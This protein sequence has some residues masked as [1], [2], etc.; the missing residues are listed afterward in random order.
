M[1][2][3]ALLLGILLVAAGLL[4]LREPLQSQL[5]KLSD[6]G[7]E[8]TASIPLKPM[9]LPPELKQNPNL[10]EKY[11]AK[12]RVRSKYFL[13]SQYYTPLLSGIAEATPW[14]LAERDYYLQQLKA[15]APYDVLVVPT[16][17]AGYSDLAS[18]RYTAETW[19]QLL[20]ANDFNS[21]PIQPV[22]NILGRHQRDYSDE[23]V[24]Q[25]ADELKVKAIY[26][27]YAGDQVDG[28]QGY[29]DQATGHMVPMNR[30]LK[31][32]VVKETNTTQAP[33]LS[34]EFLPEMHACNLNG[35]PELK[36]TA[37]DFFAECM[38]E[39]QQQ[40][41][42]T[43][44]IGKTLVTD[45]VSPELIT[46]GLPLSSD[47][48][49]GNLVE[50]AYYVQLLAT[51]VPDDAAFVEA[52]LWLKSLLILNKLDPQSTDYKSLKARAYLQLGM[53]PLAL[54]TLGEP[55]TAIEQSVR[56]LMD[57]NLYDLKAAAEAIELPVAKLIARIDY[58]TMLYRYR[59]RFNSDDQKEITAL[60]E[61]NPALGYELNRRVYDVDSWA[62]NSNVDLKQYLD[63]IYPGPR[64]LEEA[65]VQLNWQPNSTNDFSD[66]IELEFQ[67]HIDVLKEK[68]DQPHADGAVVSAM[69][70]LTLLEAIG[71]I[72]LADRIRFLASTQ[73]RPKVAAETFA[74]YETRLGGQVDLLKA[75]N[76]LLA[77]QAE[78]A[79]ATERAEKQ[80]EEERYR[81]TYVYY[82]D[83]PNRYPH[84]ENDE[85][86]WGI[87]SIGLFQDRIA[88]ALQRKGR[89]EPQLLTEFNS[90]FN[91]SPYK[92]NVELAIADQAGGE[93]AV[94]PVIEKA[95]TQFDDVWGI[96]WLYVKLQAGNGEFGKADKALKDYRPF[97][98]ESRSYNRVGISQDAYDAGNLF[99]NNG[100]FDRAKYY[101][102][103]SADLRT[104]SGGSIRA[105]AKLALLEHDYL[106][107]YQGF[108]A[109][110]SRYNKTY[111][112]ATS[113]S[114][115]SLLG[116][117]E[118]AFNLDKELLTKK[119]HK[120][121]SDTL[122]G[123]ARFNKESDENLCTW[124]TTSAKEA[125]QLLEAGLLHQF[126]YT[127]DNL[128]R[129]IAG[130][131]ASDK[132]LNCAKKVAGENNDYSDFFTALVDF[133]QNFYRRDFV[134]AR[135]SFDTAQRACYQINRH[136]MKFKCLLPEYNI[137]LAAAMGQLEESKI[138]MGIK[139][140][141]Q[142]AIKAAFDGDHE[143]ALKWLNK[144]W[145]GYRGDGF[146][147][148]RVITDEYL[149]ATLV[150][151]L[152]DKTGDE[153]YAQ[154][155]VKKMQGFETIEP[156]HSWPYA[157]EA[158]YST[159]K[160]RVE[161]AL[162]FTLYLDPN[163][164][165]I[166]DFSEA[167]KEQARQWLQANLE[168]ELNVKEGVS[169]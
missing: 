35:D 89:I 91:G 69:D 19:Q 140:P 80:A 99:Y 81:W 166:A 145:V 122:M 44:N 21:V 133:H 154:L 161:R 8:A 94:I 105:F 92:M 70:H 85:I 27:L 157:V 37:I 84:R 97:F 65:L 129:A 52:D 164:A 18:R 20:L 123:L 13:K 100:Q 38:P 25:L 128:D 82:Y 111:D 144:A 30:E 31:L 40:F 50:Q 22:L 87:N 151:A 118:L 156:W 23:A 159:D 142:S 132:L 102:K 77:V 6:S 169:Y 61:S 43:N 165:R 56:A 103:I 150:E 104:G 112:Y 33:W 53:R 121:L 71:H 76:D 55:T 158:K 72:N 109:G 1:G 168:K 41:G 29:L 67:N 119:P 54:T 114:L 39:L 60:L 137:Y 9:Q 120:L 134:A 115:M 98:E 42:L 86:Y 46:A 16:Q 36:R 131:Q 147:P 10:P 57:G 58:F 106:T 96:T 149:F 11:R 127:Q 124:I 160:Q 17:N 126:A 88:K 83:A 167:D 125:P 26:W 51:L 141:M 153:R 62:Q 107:A 3:K 155:L 135:T 66:V 28:T 117:G 49:P 113:L 73:G 136:G 64:D 2:R 47:T 4:L 139:P 59:G 34:S 45:A 152:I 32:A 90:R 93:A 78:D 148:K 7:E 68:M 101:F 14:Q 143:S 24:Y 12:G 79:N 48:H 130:R 75:R 5:A 108:Y 146:N 15:N 116:K 162:A 63:L 95:L 138:T 163:S 110:A 74:I